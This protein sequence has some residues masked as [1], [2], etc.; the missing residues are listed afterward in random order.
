MRRVVL[1]II[2]LVISTVFCGA[3][4]ADAGVSGAFDLAQYNKIEVVTTISQNAGV[5]IEESVAITKQ[6]QSYIEEKTVKTLAPI[7]SA[8]QYVETS[9]TTEYSLDAYQPALAI[10]LS[11][12]TVPQLSKT[13]ETDGVRRLELSLTAEEAELL[14]QQELSSIADNGFLL[15][16][17]FDLEENVMD[18]L[19][20]A[21]LTDRGNDVSIAVGFEV[22]QA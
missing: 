22:E 6:E 15:T 13:V 19:T 3:C 5:V 18:S 8:T 20:I 2:M 10:D 21:Y 4:D 11:R 14:M 7:D 1:L 16:I 17:I 12:L 9:K